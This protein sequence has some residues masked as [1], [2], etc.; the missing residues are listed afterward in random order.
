MKYILTS[1]P[2]Y[3]EENKVIPDNGFIE[4]LKELLPEDIHALYVAS[5]PDDRPLTEE[6]WLRLY[7]S[8]LAAGL[9][10][11]NYE[12]LD[13][14]SDAY[15]KELIDGADWIILSGGHVPTQNAYFQEIGL[16]E[17]L[18]GYEGL[19]MGISAGSMNMA[20]TVYAEP[21][22]PLELGD[23]TYK[24][25]IPGLGITTANILPHYNLNAEER[26]LGQ[27]IY[28]DIA[29]KDS[30]KLPESLSE[31]FRGFFV[32]PDGSFI[33]GDTKEPEKGSGRPTER[34]FGEALIIKNGVFEPLSQ[35]DD[36]IRL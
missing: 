10:I 20:D 29:R 19:V 32:L 9:R 1:S 33:L 26:L 36:V 17:K 2:L 11:V 6:Y 25:W 34:L 8:F 5:V 27:H 13:R 21:E 18:R 15:A 24:R 23:L 16:R 31:G 4:I 28:K 22:Y 14:K 35:K 7:D 30:L 12:I 3:D